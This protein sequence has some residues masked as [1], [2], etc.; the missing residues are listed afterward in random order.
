[1]LVAVGERKEARK[2]EKA[3]VGVAT[4]T[5]QGAFLTPKIFGLRQKLISTLLADRISQFTNENEADIF[6][7]YPPPSMWI[8]SIVGA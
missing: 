3:K 7:K 6:T 1:M 2:I 5:R 4:A 8:C